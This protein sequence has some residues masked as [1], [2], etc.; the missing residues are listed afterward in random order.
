MKLQSI[1]SGQ[2]DSSSVASSPLEP[3]GELS[4]M[5]PFTI[6]NLPKPTSPILPAW[7]LWFPGIPSKPKA[8]F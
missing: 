7:K 6:L 3:H 2:A 8:S 4:A 1:V 5:E